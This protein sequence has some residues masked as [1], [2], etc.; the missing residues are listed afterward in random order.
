MP[1]EV[2]GVSAQTLPAGTYLFKA[3]ESTADR[4]IIQ[5]SSPDGSQVFTTMIG[6]P[7]SRLKAPDLITVIFTNRP[8][9][10]PVALKVFYCPGRTWGDQLVYEKPRAAQLAKESN[11]PV[12]STSVVQA[13]AS[14]AVLKTALVEAVGP[15]GE[16]VAVA[17][18][19]D[20]PA[21]V[22]PVVA[23][24]PAVSTTEG[25][26]VVVASAP[27][28][29]ITAAVA[30]PPEVESASATEPT[31]SATPTV[32]EVSPSPA[33]EPTV[34]VAAPPPPAP[35]TVEPFA[36]PAPAA[37]PEPVAAAMPPPPASTV[38]PEPAI[39]VSPEVATAT[40]PKTASLLPLV[41]LAG[42]LLLGSGFLLTSLM[43]QRA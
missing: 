7:N 27:A 36:T 39:A 6:I 1:V 29:E 4:D 32:A 40:L 9:A 34:A 13:M 14:E 33:I 10:D 2:P 12:L 25:A 5:V 15:D 26:T 43:K 22:A 31:V 21:V 37:A 19:V 11:E 42:L 8:A 3:L 30:P 41:G 20:V 38:T 18:V 24:S 16:T 17:Q 35:V 28:P 23:A